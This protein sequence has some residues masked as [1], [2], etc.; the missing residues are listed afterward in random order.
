[1]E[2]HPR[3]PPKYSCIRRF[4]SAPTSI[5]L[6]NRTTNYQKQHSIVQK[7]DG[8]LTFAPINRFALTLPSEITSEIFLHCLPDTEFV[9]PDPSSAPL[10]LC[11]I[12]REWRQIALAT[13]RLWGS[14]YLDL[15][16]FVR[17]D[18]DLDQDQ[19]ADLDQGSNL[20]RLDVG[21]FFCDWLANARNTPLSVNIDQGNCFRVD[22]TIDEDQLHPV[23]KRIGQRSAQW[24]TIRLFVFPKHLANLFPLQGEFFQLRKLS[25]KFDWEVFPIHLPRALKNAFS[26]REIQFYGRPWTSL[27]VPWGSLSVF[28][29]EKMNI[30]D[31]VDVLRNATNLSTCT[32]SLVPYVHSAPIP[33]LAP[34]TNLH[35]LSLSQRADTAPLL[36]DLLHHLTLPSLKHLTLRFEDSEDGPPADISEFSFFASRS[37]LQL[38]ALTLCFVPTSEAGLIQCLQCMQSLETLELQMR[39]TVDAVLERLTWNTHFLP[40]LQSLHIMHSSSSWNRPEPE[41]HLDPGQEEVLEMLSSRWYV[42]RDAVQLRSFRYQHDAGSN[43][44]NILTAS[45]ISDPRYQL[46]EEAGMVLCFEKVRLLAAPKWCLD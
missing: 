21:E 7:A 19:D 38:Q 10:L 42:P 41:V 16:W 14:L 46:L 3:S 12:C 39:T 32:V 45:V 8:A 30:T 44:M 29:S 22:G 33:S 27:T 4:T 28:G 1:M 17:R 6:S 18:L 20:D 15:N 24:Q 43:T 5:I 23:L 9:E 35:V 31:C 25:I 36:M 13:A 2:F 11:Y 40:R 34:I 37:S 26:L